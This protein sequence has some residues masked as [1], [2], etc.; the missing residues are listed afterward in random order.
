MV[1]V[2]G[3][4]PHKNSLGEEF[5][6]LLLMGGLE[7]IKSNNSGRYYATAR[8]ASVPSTFPPEVARGFI[9]SQIP[10]SVKKVETEPYEYAVEGGELITLSHRYEYAPDETHENV[11]AGEVVA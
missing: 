2:T 6:V 11:F 1:T 10:G 5:F 4:E 3:V 9:G 7:M 8:K